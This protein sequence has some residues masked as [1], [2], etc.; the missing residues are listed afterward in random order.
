MSIIQ[1]LRK[2]FKILAL[3]LSLALIVGIIALS[4][5]QGKF[6][7]GEIFDIDGTTGEAS[8]QLIEGETGEVTDLS[9]YAE[10]DGGSDPT[11][12]AEGEYPGE[13]PAVGVEPDPHLPEGQDPF[14]AQD[15]NGNPE[16]SN[17]PAVGEDPTDLDLPPA[18]EEPTNPDLP[19][20][21][22]EPTNPDLPPD[23]EEPIE[24]DLPPN[25]EEPAA[26]SLPPEGEEADDDS[27][28]PEWREPVG[29][30]AAQ[31]LG[32]SAPGS[33][34]L[35]M[36]T[37]MNTYAPTIGSPTTAN[38]YLSSGSVPGY[39][40]DYLN[41]E[42]M[43]SRNTFRWT[44][45][46]LEGLVPW[47]G[48]PSSGSAPPNATAP[49]LRGNETMIPW[50]SGSVYEIWSGEQFRYA[51]DKA[52]TGQTIKL[53]RNLDLNG[54]TENW[55]TG[56]PTL[57]GVTIDGNN[58]TIYNLG[59]YKSALIV[60]F[61]N[62]TVRDVTFK[63]AKLVTDGGRDC[64]LFIFFQGSTAEHVTIEDS[65]FFNN[66]TSVGKNTAPLVAQPTN[67]NFDRIAIKNT[68]VYGINHVGG[69]IAIP[70]NCTITNSF[71][72]DG[73]IIS[74]GGHSGGFSSC[75]DYVCTIRN[76]F[77]NN[78]VFGAGQTGGFEGYCAQTAYVNCYSS[79]SVE[80]YEALGGFVALSSKRDNNTYST[81]TNCYST[82][83]VGMRNGGS[84]LGGFVGNIL[85]PTT[86]KNCY[87]AGEVGA[88]D[89]DV[90]P[91]R[92]T[93]KDVGGF[94]GTSS[95][96]SSFT[97]CYYDKQTTAMRE[98]ASGSSQTVGGVNGVYTDDTNKNGT[99]YSGL[100]SD[101][102]A[103]GFLGFSSDQVPEWVMT[104]D[105]MY[106]QLNVFINASTFAPETRDLVRAFSQASVSTVHLDAW[107][108]D[109]ENNDL[110]TTSYD[111]V[112]DVTAR[113]KM[114]SNARSRW[115]SDGVTSTVANI[116]MPV[117]NLAQSNGVWYAGKFVP[118]TEWLEV[119]V[120]VNGSVGRRR[121]RI[122]P[123]MNLTAGASQTVPSTMLY[124]HA[125]DVRFVY[126]TG[127]RMAMNPNDLTLGVYPDLPLSLSQ[128]TFQSV[129]PP[130]FPTSD[131]LYSNVNIG[132][133]AAGSTME[134][135]ISPVTSIDPTTGQL[136][137]GAELPLRKAPTDPG[138]QDKW[139]GK[140][141]FEAAD[142]D[143]YLLE[144]FWILPDGR[145]MR[146]A[147]TINVINA[148]L[149]LKISV[150]NADG[151]PNNWAMSID[152]REKANPLSLAT[153]DTD[154]ITVDYQKPG[155]VSWKVNDP[156]KTQVLGFKIHTYGNQD[157][158]FDL[159]K[160]GS[161]G[162]FQFQIPYTY[163]NELVND[164]SYSYAPAHIVNKNYQITQ[165]GNGVY[166]LAFDQTATNIRNESFPDMER[167]IEITLI[168]QADRDY[169]MH[170]RQVIV[171]RTTSVIALP[172]NGFIRMANYDALGTVK[173]I[174]AATCLSG[175]GNVPYSD[176]LF[177]V[178]VPVEKFFQLYPILPQF[179]QYVGHDV[180]YVD[181]NASFGP[182]TSRSGK[183]IVDYRNGPEAWAT[184]FL[185]PVTEEPH[186]YD[187]D[188]A[189]NRFGKVDGV[190]LPPSPPVA[191]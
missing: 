176:Y 83:I 138:L 169:I 68:D 77:T 107:E 102:G 42:W 191:P 136:Y 150:E 123:T 3:T 158:L 178:S 142:A 88:I 128:V 55:S 45:T 94:Y 98:W 153:S 145:Y 53:M 139:N 97:N 117:L 22:E 188:T 148:P 44:N 181:G 177:G 51:M 167:S 17:P 105:G 25:G 56:L 154:L 119:D 75:N 132:H 8:E 101:P 82:T 9:G 34:D 2:H 121:L 111:T 109:F 84:K 90:S 162:G 175:V 144:Y 87:A 74:A 36:N 179:Y 168:V 137:T 182:G 189:I 152:A 11:T 127:P 30:R 131:D 124:D 141:H 71:A 46:S 133:V 61:K 184:I 41:Q 89:T 122:I 155:V 80:G 20:D 50:L 130:S 112:R 73:V 161:L 183:I 146:A 174:T 100:D 113:F 10:Y 13:G 31:L 129:V 54:A 95:T 26:E 173:S 104:K 92:T 23:G 47:S 37:I 64:G 6:S 163:R 63:S 149:A 59:L 78:K 164:P 126:S 49:S 69:A 38:P 57:T 16:E 21:G 96:T 79:G 115:Q 81:F 52:T 110:P 4:A 147:K 14:Q 40:I 32:A 67:S 93:F 43:K 12:W 1:K 48:G 24:I 157:D 151:T 135:V 165:D 143:R 190:K 5:L 7:E 60:T 103:N 186:R 72:I 125:D 28:P 76:C 140:R 35:N 114:T 29:M 185:E 160:N 170:V 172:Q 86:F 159:T 187:W 39:W 120:T 134:T 15:P 166:H 180:S 33:N 58:K 91:G 99:L 85:V 66:A 18:G 70:N 106:P 118:G 108:K 62:G 19:P 27:L 116:T 65:L 171:N 156:Q